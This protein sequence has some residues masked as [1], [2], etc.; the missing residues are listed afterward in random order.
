MF[1]LRDSVKTLT[2]VCQL[3]FP[4][5]PCYY[6]SCFMILQYSIVQLK[7]KRFKVISRPLAYI[8]AL[9]EELPIDHS[10][11]VNNC[12]FLK[13]HRFLVA[14]A[15]LYDRENSKC[16]S[17][18]VQIVTTNKNCI[19]RNEVL[20]TGTLEYNIKTVNNLTESLN[21]NFARPSDALLASE[22]EMSQ[23]NIFCDIPSDII[24]AVLKQYFATP[25]FLNKN[26]VISINVKEY[27]A[28]HYFTN[29]Q[30]NGVKTIYFKC[31]RV[32]N[33]KL[34]HFDGSFVC[35]ADH[36]SLK[37][38]SNVQSFVPKET[39]FITR[40]NQCIIDLCPFGLTQHFEDLKAS[41]KPFLT[42]SNAFVYLVKCKSFLN[43][44]I[45]SRFKFE[46]IIFNARQ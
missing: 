44:F 14:F 40:N 25:K 34:S 10:I 30:V 1:H 41:I 20:V 6:F 45:S 38:S 24:D 36:T 46:T 23:V 13:G 29:K 28:K 27:A 11:D 4:K 7:Q 39:A 15:K 12:V 21:I 2:Y 16:T 42:K 43:I 37:L 17:R 3:L 5:Y 22:V 31:N 18:F 19:E 35:V 33:S 8:K 26:D 9:L 32:F